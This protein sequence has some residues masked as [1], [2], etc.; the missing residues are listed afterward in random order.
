MY[1]GIQTAIR[2][3]FPVK[4]IYLTFKHLKH[5]FIGPL[6]YNLTPSYRYVYLCGLRLFPIPIHPTDTKGFIHRNSNDMI[7]RSLYII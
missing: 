2:I 7:S 3:K 6:F 1:S 4:N 5:F